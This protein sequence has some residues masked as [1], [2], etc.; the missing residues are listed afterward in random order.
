MTFQAR[1]IFFLLSITNCT[2]LFAS[3]TLRVNLQQADSL[4]LTNNYFLLASLMN[5]EVQKAQ[6]LQAKLYPN[7]VFTA[8][9]NAYDPQNQKLLHVGQ[10]GQKVFQIEQ[11]I[12]LGGKRKSE[13]ELART[14]ADIATLE[15]Q[16]LVRQLRFRL[17]TS[18]FKL[19]QQQYLLDRYNVQLALVDSIMTG[20][21]RQVSKGNMPL[22]DL[23]RLRGVY[24]ALNNDRAELLKQYFE[25]QSDIQSLLQTTNIVLFT[26]SDDEITS[27]IKTR[28]LQ[29]LKLAALGNHPQLLILQGN[30]A[31]ALQYLQYQK[32]SAVPDVNIFTSYDQRGGAFNNQVNMGVAVPLPFWNRNQGN[33]KAANY[34]I[35]ET[36]YHVNAKKQEVINNLQNSY[37]LYTH[38]V[39]EYH[40]VS[41]LYNQD[42]EITL[43]G[44]SENFQKRNI[45]LIEFVD[46]FEAYNETIAE[47]ARIKTQLVTSAEQLNLSVGVD[48]Y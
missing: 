45:S 28:D 19:G 40:K 12:M 14:N 33:I 18:L 8:D 5:I 31:M 24:L 39:Y 46:F 16:D 38:T 6:I 41:K 21:E 29:E 44:I 1:L 36:E 11:L 34:R 9:V 47:M 35:K 32:R 15:F 43:K 4:F 37:A 20:Y 25:A 26:F 7:P 3:D 27:Y 48:I 10:T 17:H 22:S 30:Q 2:V 42:F 13:I 23:V